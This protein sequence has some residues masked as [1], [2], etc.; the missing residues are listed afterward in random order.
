[1]IMYHPDSEVLKNLNG[2]APAIDK[3]F[4]VDNTP[5]S[6]GVLPESPDISFTVIH[7][8]TNV[9]IAKALNLA[10]HNALKE[11]YN[12]LLTMDQDSTFSP[13]Y[14]NQYLDC[15]GGVENMRWGMCGVNY[16]Q[17]SENQ[18]CARIPSAKLITSGSVLNLMHFAKTNGFDENLFIDGV[19]FEYCYQLNLLGLDTFYFENIRM[20][21]SLGRQID[22]KNFHIGPKVSRNVHSSVRLYYMLRNYLYLRKKYRIHFPEVTR[23]SFKD[24]RIRIK[25]AILYTPERARTIGLLFRA[26]RDFRNGNM[27]ELK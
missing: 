23:D 10:V 13:G 9:G 2:Y 15:L 1:M 16:L 26:I 19:D 25:N 18:F 7:T 6:S 4:I 24:L 12:Y 14:F 17:Q 22:V 8:G 3:L 5:G 27:G 20:E 21:H 11:G